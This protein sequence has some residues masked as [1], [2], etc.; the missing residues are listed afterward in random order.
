VL[1]ALSSASCSEVEDRNALVVLTGAGK[2]PDSRGSRLSVRQGGMRP[3]SRQGDPLPRANSHASGPAGHTESETSLRAALLLDPR[4][5]M[6]PADVLWL[7]PVS[8][9]RLLKTQPETSDLKF[10][11]FDEVWIHGFCNSRS[12]DFMI[13]IVMRRYRKTHQPFSDAGNPAV[14]M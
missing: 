6:V 1:P 5:Y 13:V 14:H 3:S 7:P 8:R 2:T 10:L 4:S 9:F 12:S 11:I